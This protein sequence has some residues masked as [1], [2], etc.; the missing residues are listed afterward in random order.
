MPRISYLRMLSLTA[1]VVVTACA[2]KEEPATTAGADSSAVP[3]NATGGPTANVVTINASDYK[4][5]APDQIP[6]GL[7]TFKLVDTGKEPHHATLIKL[8]EGKTGADLQAA[9]K[10]MKPGTP[11]PAWVVLAGGPNAIAPGGESNATLVLEPGNYALVCFIPDPKGVPHFA[12]GMVKPLTVTAA[13]TGTAPEPI[14]DITL[15]LSD[16]RFDWSK[17]LTAGRHTIRVETLPGQPHEVTLFK[18]APGKSL[19]DLI[20]WV[21]SGMGGPPP[22]APIGGIAGVAPGIPSTFTIDLQ[23]GDYAVVCFL[24]DHKDGKPHFVH[25]MTQ[26]IKVT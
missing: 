5:E 21:Q 3:G 20:G 17:P 15:R 9:M 18:L 11:P 22:A 2:V 26:A 7:T 10:T 1:V 6:A 14:P 24:E 16:Y 19:K 23:A 12:L 13:V 8:T 4:F 25:G